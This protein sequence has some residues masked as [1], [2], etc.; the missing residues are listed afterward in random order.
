MKWRLCDAYKEEELYWKQKNRVNWLKEGDKNTNF[1]HTTTKQRRAMNR[2]I[3]LHGLY[4]V[5]IDNEDG[6]DKVVVEYFDQLLPLPIRV[7]SLKF[8]GMFLC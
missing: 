6:I 5:W 2:I 3:G 4:G 1:F 7:F 8:S